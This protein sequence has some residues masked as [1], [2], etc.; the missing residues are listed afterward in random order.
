[1][2]SSSPSISLCHKFSA[3]RLRSILFFTV[4]FAAFFI[5]GLTGVVFT[6][7]CSTPQHKVLKAVQVGMDKAAVLEIVGNPTRIT[8][9]LGQDRWSYE[10]A[11]GAGVNG[12]AGGSGGAE[13]RTT[14]VYF[15]EGRVTYVGSAAVDSA[16][17]SPAT[18]KV[19]GATASPSGK[20]A[21]DPKNSGFKSVG[22]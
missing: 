2:F 22:E 8:R 13:K 5:L 3:V 6:A 16:A 4:S 17:S 11:S 15:S 9:H 19:G 14:Y 10:E 18:D 1:M 21:S 12:D 7:G 20:V